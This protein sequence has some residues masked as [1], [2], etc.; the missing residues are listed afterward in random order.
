VLL[1][2]E[3]ILTQKLANSATTRAWELLPHSRKWR[4]IYS[5]IYWILS[6]ESPRILHTHIFNHVIQFALNNLK[7]IITLITFNFQNT[8]VYILVHML[9]YNKIKWSYPTT[10]FTLVQYR[11]HTCYTRNIMYIC[12]IH[13]GINVL[14]IKTICTLVHKQEQVNVMTII[15]T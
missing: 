3:T 8:N 11:L 5:V 15:V 1:Q 7:F 13:A 4:Q 6:E 9:K 12:I 10:C 14:F 2:R